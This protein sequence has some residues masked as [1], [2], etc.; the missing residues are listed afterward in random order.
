[1]NF[2]NYL[3]CK[4]FYKS[5]FT[6]QFSAQVIFATCLRFNF[7]FTFNLFNTVSP[8]CTFCCFSTWSYNDQRYFILFILKRTAVF[9]SSLF[10]FCNKIHAH[11]YHCHFYWTNVT[12]FFLLDGS[13][14][15]FYRP[16]LFFVSYCLFYC[17]VLLHEQ[18]SMAVLFLELVYRHVKK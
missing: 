18:S 8:P 17:L 13:L 10:L 12:I 6:I 1:M 14:V 3:W 9:S 16:S 11:R 7:L 2:I 15:P 4:F 5:V